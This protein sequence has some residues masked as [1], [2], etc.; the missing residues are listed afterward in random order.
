MC[1][2]C[3][4]SSRDCRY[5]ERA[6][7]R[8]FDSSVLLNG[9]LKSSVDT[10]EPFDDNQTWLSIPRRRKKIHKKDSIHQI[11][12]NFLTLSLVT[13]I[14]IED[15]YDYDSPSLPECELE[16]LD[17]P[18]AHNP[19][20]ETTQTPHPGKDETSD[21]D[22]DNLTQFSIALNGDEPLAIPRLN[23]DSYDNILA[24][25]LLRHFKEGPGQW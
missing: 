18:V 10:R 19:D 8:T 7:F 11:N 16:N 3:T 20:D 1:Q 17:Q 5:V 21:G 14:N 15:P 24:L 9:K 4:K 2:N 22:R 25:R 6:V 23:D 12:D 13:F